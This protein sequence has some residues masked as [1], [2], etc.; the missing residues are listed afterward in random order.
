MKK[1]K[2]LIKPKSIF[3]ADFIP[4]LTNTSQKKRNELRS[5]FDLDVAT[6]SSLLLV[7]E[8]AIKLCHNTGKGPKWIK[9]IIAL[10]DEDENVA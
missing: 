9:Q 10:V 6:I 2:K 7:E 5:R 3:L 8:K 4:L 1:I